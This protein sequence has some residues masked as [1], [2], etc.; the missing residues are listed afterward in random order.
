MC[1]VYGA[2]AFLRE[3]KAAFARKKQLVAAVRIEE[4]LADAISHAE[5]YTQK[6]T[7]LESRAVLLCDAEIPT[8]IEQYGL[9]IYVKLQGKE[10]PWKKS[11]M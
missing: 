7:Y 6:Y 10:E 11:R 2:Y 3:I 1:A 4:N 9:D 5:F 8:D